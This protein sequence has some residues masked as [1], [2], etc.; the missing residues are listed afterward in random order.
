[1]RVDTIG[2]A[3]KVLYA[4]YIAPGLVEW[5]HGEDAKIDGERVKDAAN[6]LLR[7]L[8]EETRWVLRLMSS[9]EGVPLGFAVERETED[10]WIEGV[11][12]WLDPAERNGTWLPRYFEKLREIAKADGMRGI[13]F[14]STLPLFRFAAVR[15][16]FR[17][18][19]EYPQ[20]G[21]PPV[22]EWIQEV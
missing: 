2:H 12:L 17:K 4:D 1:M 18:G 14:R 3:D 21:G 13:R 20:A 15:S 19:E 22:V 7:K 11:V 9:S 16:G 10:D 5:E 6:L 8:Y